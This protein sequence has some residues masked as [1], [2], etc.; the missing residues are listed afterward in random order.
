[1]FTHQQFEQDSAGQHVTCPLSVSWGSST[2]AG[3]PT[4]KPALSHGC[5]VGVGRQV[6]S[7]GVSPWGHL[8]FLPA[9]WL[10]FEN[11]C[12]KRQEVEAVSF[13]RPGPQNW[14][15]VTSTIFYW[16]SNLIAQIQKRGHKFHISMAGVA[17]TRTCYVPGT[18]ETEMI[19]NIY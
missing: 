19:T 5:L 2:R 6:L 12:P 9:W 15:S 7:M 18:E 11:Q 17:M 4:S 14:H 10:G 16:L 1:M 8:G 13:L 3:R